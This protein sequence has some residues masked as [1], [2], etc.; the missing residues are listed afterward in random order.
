MGLTNILHGADLRLFIFILSYK[1]SSE[2]RLSK[3][4]NRLILKK[5]SI[6]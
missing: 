4:K 5:A 1:L 2:L 3:N 6:K